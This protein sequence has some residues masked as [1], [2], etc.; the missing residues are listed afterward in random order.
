MSETELKI[1][2]AVIFG[3]RERGYAIVSLELIGRISD[4][5]HVNAKPIDDL[6]QGY[7]T[8]LDKIIGPPT[9]KPGW[10]GD[11]SGSPFGPSDR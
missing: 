1:V 4:Y 6:A 10:M 5:F 11:I 7:M 9:I 8:E 2:D 3:L